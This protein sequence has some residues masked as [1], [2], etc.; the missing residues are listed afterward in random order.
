MPQHVPLSSPPAMFVGNPHLLN[1]SDIHHILFDIGVLCTFSHHKSAIKPINGII[2]VE[3]HSKIMS[4]YWFIMLC[5]F[6][7]TK[8]PS[9]TPWNH[10]S[11]A[12]GAPAPAVPRSSGW[13]PWEVPWPKATLLENEA[14]HLVKYRLYFG[15]LGGECRNIT[16]IYDFESAVEFE[17]TIRYNSHTLCFYFVLAKPSARQKN[18]VS[19]LRMKC[20]LGHC[21]KMRTCSVL[22]PIQDSIGMHWEDW[23]SE[24]GE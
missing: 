5:W 21:N 18:A 1:T 6:H 12:S 11:S 19:S 20:R 23:R 22:D 3:S 7:P 17:V 8:S 16:R 2:I 14:V 24:I 10:A 9:N 13:I 15:K 4:L